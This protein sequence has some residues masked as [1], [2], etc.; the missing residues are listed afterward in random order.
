MQLQGQKKVII[1]IVA[2]IWCIIKATIEP[3]I[4]ITKAV[5]RQTILL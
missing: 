4:Q 3:I 1:V 5:Y 2:Y